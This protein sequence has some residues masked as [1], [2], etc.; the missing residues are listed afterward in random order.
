[1]RRPGAM[2]FHAAL[3]ASHGL[4]GFGDVQFIPITHEKRLPLTLREASKLLLNYFKYL[5][6]FQ[7]LSRLLG[8]FG[9]ARLE[10]VK[11]V[12]VVVLATPW[13]ERGEQRGPER[14]HFLSPK[15]VADGILHDA[16]EKQ[17]QLGDRAV[18][19][20]FRQPQHGILDD[21]ERRFLLAQREYRLLES[22]P[23]DAFEKRGE[24][25]AGCQASL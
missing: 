7:D 16:V 4:G 15:V 25:A 2:R 11:W 18:A 19:V 22:T 20:L 17:R 13:R 3:R 5:T 6:S 12:G 1:M 24:L 14:A 9:V 23:L 8:G 10:R 21:V